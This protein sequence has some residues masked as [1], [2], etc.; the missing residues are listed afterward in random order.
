MLLNMLTRGKIHRLLISIAIASQL[1]LPG[2]LP[3]GRAQADINPAYNF[4][5]RVTDAAGVAMPDGAYDFSFAFFDAASGGARLWSED[6]TAGNCFRATVTGK[7]VGADTVTYAYSGELA[8]STLRAGQDLGTPASSAGYAIVGFDLGARTITTVLGSST[9]AIGA[10]IDNR[11]RVQSGIADIDLGSVNGLAGLDFNVPLY[12][13]VIFNGEVMQPRRTVTSAAQAFNAARL[14]G[15]VASDFVKSST[16]TDI[17]GF[18]NFLRNL[19]IGSTTASSSLTVYGDFSNQG[20]ATT[21]GSAYVGTSLFIGGSLLDSGGATGTAGMV[22]TSTGTSTQWQAQAAAEKVYELDPS[23]TS[24]SNPYIAYSHGEDVIRIKEIGLDNH[25][26]N[27][28]LGEEGS[29]SAFIFMPNDDP[30]SAPD[31]A[32]ITSNGM[33]AQ[34]VD[35]TLPNTKRIVIYG[36]RSDAVTTLNT[37]LVLVMSSNGAYDGGRLFSEMYPGLTNGFEGKVIIQQPVRNAITMTYGG[38]GFQNQ[39]QYDYP[40]SFFGSDNFDGWG[41]TPGLNANGQLT[42]YSLNEQQFIGLTGSG[43]SA[44]I[45]GLGRAWD[46]SNANSN[47]IFYASGNV[48]NVGIGTDMPGKK[49]TVNGEVLIGSDTGI[50]PQTVGL[51]IIGQADNHIAAFIDRDKTAGMTYDFDSGSN[52]F[53]IY[54]DYYAD[55]PEPGFVLGTFSHKDDQLVLSSNG[56]IGI[57]TTTPGSILT[58]A[59][60]VQITG[61]LCLSSGCISGNVAAWETVVHSTPDETIS[62]TQADLYK[63]HKVAASGVTFDFQN[64][65]ANGIGYGKKVSFELEAASTTL[66]NDGFY[67]RDNLKSSGSAVLERDV[68]GRFFELTSVARDYVN[69]YDGWIVENPIDRNQYTH[70]LDPANTGLGISYTYYGIADDLSNAPISP[71]DGE[72]L[73]TDS[74]YSYRYDGSFNGGAWRPVTDTN[75]ANIIN[76]LSYPSYSAGAKQEKSLSIGNREG[77]AYLAFI[78]FN[79]YPTIDQ[80]YTINGN[81]T[82]SQANYVVILPSRTNA[83]SFASDSRMQLAGYAANGD[84]YILDGDTTNQLI[85]AAKDRYWHA[86]SGP[87]FSVTSAADRIFD[88]AFGNDAE[89]DSLGFLRRWTLTESQYN[90]I[91]AGMGGQKKH[92]VNMDDY[93][94][95]ISYNADVADEAE[96]A[97]MPNPTVGEWRR[98]LDTGKA[99]VYTGQPY[100]YSNENVAGWS[101]PSNNDDGKDW[102]LPKY[103]VGS[104]DENIVEIHNGSNLVVEL[105]PNMN[106]LQKYPIGST[107]TIM[108]DGAGDSLYILTGSVVNRLKAHNLVTDPVI[109]MRDVDGIRL[110]YASTYTFRNIGRNNGTEAVWTYDQSSTISETQNKYGP[111]DGWG[112]SAVLNLTESAYQRFTLSESQYQAITGETFSGS[113]SY[114]TQGY[115]GWVASSSQGALFINNGYNIGIGTDTPQKTLD[116]QGQVRVSDNIGI[117][118]QVGDY[119]N[120]SSILQIKTSTDGRVMDMYS[121]GITSRNFAEWYQD[122]SDFTGNGLKMDFA[123]DGSG[124]FTG[125]FL[126]FLN[127]DVEQAYVSATGSAYF[128]GGIVEKTYEIDGNTTG[129]GIEVK[130]TFDTIADLYAAEAAGEIVAGGLYKVLE[131]QEYGNITTWHLR[132]RGNADWRIG[133]PRDLTQQ[134]YTLGSNGETTL[135]LKNQPVIKLPVTT[136]INQDVTIKPTDNS[137][138]YYLLSDNINLSSHFLVDGDAALNGYELQM[139][140]ITKFTIF[141]GMWNPMFGPLL[142][143]FD[144]SDGSWANEAELNSQGRYKRYSMTENMFNSAQYGLAASTSQNLLYLNNGYGI[145]IGTS[146]SNGSGLELEKDLGNGAMFYLSAGDQTDAP[147]KIRLTDPNNQIEDRAL[148]VESNGFGVADFVHLDGGPADD[149]NIFNIKDQDPESVGKLL[150]LEGNGLGNLQ[151]LTA[152]GLTDSDMAYWSQSNSNFTGTGLKMD[153]ANSNGSFAGKFLSFINAGV[154]QSFVTAT[155]SAYFASNLLIGSSTIG[156]SS[157]P[158]S[159]S[160][161]AFLSEGG[162]WTNASD[163]NLKENFVAL[164]KA[165]ILE[166]LKNLEIKQ[167]NYKS[168]NDSTKHVGPTAQDF[169]AAFMLGGSDRSISTIDPAGVALLGIQAL[170]EQIGSINDQI[171]LD[172]ATSAAKVEIINKTTENKKALLVM[173]QNIGND[174]ASFRTP[175]AE[176]LKVASDGEV[177]VVGTLSVDGRTLVCAGACPA[178]LAA[179]IDATRGDIGAEGK[180]VANSFESYCESGYTW[181]KGSAKYGTMPGFCAMANLASAD[182]AGAAVSDSFSA[183]WTDL[184][185]SQ[186]QFACMKGA[187]HLLNENEWLTI[188]ENIANNAANDIDPLTAGLQF[189]KTAGNHKLQSGKL[190]TD[191]AGKGEWIDLSLR[192]ADLPEPASNARQ[193]YNSI[194]SFKV[195]GD[196][197]PPINL[198]DT[199]NRIGQILVGDNSEAVRGVIRGEQ[200]LYDLDL[201]H[202][203]QYK[204]ENVGFR[205]AK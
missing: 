69:M 10:P 174:I 181:V 205:C 41:N 169:Y 72:W 121:T 28:P 114:Q 77:G 130:Q 146:T 191:L 137:G 166:K 164:D 183:P 89:F 30:S 151:Y 65:T 71:N 156:T 25:D 26:Q 199:A 165:E 136:A 110:P 179:E 153:F 170:A 33:T 27:D 52:N 127:N 122:A 7:T 73:R 147:F 14:G 4:K 36:N 128:A 178:A 107:I 187:A 45:A 180:V 37:R 131:N 201:S 103:Q 91:S 195:L 117:G 149:G 142:S 194:T 16:N 50:F 184:D 34:Q 186:A 62:M 61:Q 92:V 81:P 138:D 35:A 39:W 173:Q 104:N 106:D 132:D 86:I 172:T 148:L 19:V 119:W 9:F 171:G 53:K 15:Y 5:G 44:A 75:G 32:T 155:G 108:S 123:A 101:H 31:A 1:V 11:P 197:L 120:N 193:E 167:W 145:A 143:F 200:G 20:N 48:G 98:T 168:E 18:W 2:M 94:L 47:N 152:Y 100:T 95:G 6:L 115:N 60:D 182:D 116:V 64:I 139:S 159:V 84:T 97:S 82:D 17:T 59:G 134:P 188:A 109:P 160:N 43:N 150:Y 176:I 51:E 90:S 85:Y 40:I 126:S 141:G 133:G 111:Q 12:L 144:S 118:N 63:I 79:S 124:T 163:V 157:D 66:T 125:K 190:F 198:N 203:P 49:L 129:F 3:I 204:N 140:Y 67:L 202:S 189:S 54:S 56:N 102:S 96:L 175:E 46:V 70:I 24:P 162:V 105:G 158:I 161:G 29:V 22:L 196:I 135:L 80:K 13:E 185:Q 58:V 154:E 57:G 38:N 192:L 113:D 21:S 99:W 112:N 83:P 8:T 88:G 68:D 55:V 87:L 177:K 42:R 78:I 93:G 76:D 23:L 74:G